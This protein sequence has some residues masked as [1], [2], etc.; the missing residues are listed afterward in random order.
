MKSTVG[1]GRTAVVINR[2]RAL[3]ARERGGDDTGKKS[4]FGQV[5]RTLNFVKPSH[6]IRCTAGLHAW[7]VGG[8]Y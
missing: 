8:W 2:P 3:K 4:I 1:H 6:F 5:C 7:N